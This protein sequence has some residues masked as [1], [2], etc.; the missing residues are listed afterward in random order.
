MPLYRYLALNETGRKRKG[1]IEAS[2]LESAKEL[3]L[4]QQVIVTDVKESTG[5]GERLDAKETLSFTRDLASLLNAGLPLYDS[6]QSIK[7]RWRFQKGRAL[8][9]ELVD[10][11]KGGEQLSHILP[12]NPIYC[13][14]VAAGEATG[15]LSLAFADLANLLESEQKLKRRLIAAVA[16]PAFLG[17]FCLL[18]L[19]CLLFFVIPSL[20][21][22]F[23]DRALHPLTAFVLSLS[24]GLREWWLQVSLAFASGGL[25]LYYLKKRFW[26]KIVA[27]TP[28]LKTFYLHT[29]LVHFFRS[30]SLLHE[31]GLPLL[32]SLRLAKT[33]VIFPP[34][35]RAIQ[36]AE[37]KIIE[38]KSI[39]HIWQA[40]PA[41]PPLVH[42]MIAVGEE[43]GEMAKMMNHLSKIY[44][45]ELERD[46]S[47]L[48]TFLQPVLLLTL[49][50]II[51]LVLLSVLLPL[52]DVS[53]FLN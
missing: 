10:R 2:S 32:D 41:V 4:Q 23:E 18:L 1:V 24:N 43:S 21:D 44:H 3:L 30:A 16:Y 42:R 19:F 22:L 47:Q 15:S 14:T 49:G 53:S 33:V 35:F 7:E 28:L 36:L 39:S 25:L 27:K 51:G 31:R 9:A 45:D 40:E 26:G 37:E 5:K 6:L 46:L 20:Q 48:A 29:S 11:L 52:T 38:G 12:F 13:A 8:L 34:F 50:L 17:V